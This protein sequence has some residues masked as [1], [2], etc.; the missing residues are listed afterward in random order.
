MVSVSSERAPPPD[1]HGLGQLFIQVTDP[2]YYA[3]LADIISP[4]TYVAHS[5]PG[6]RVCS[7]LCLGSFHLV[8]PIS[9]PVNL[10]DEIIWYPRTKAWIGL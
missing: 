3:Y 9:S 4:A 8:G 2:L 10:Q 6:L 7:L 1:L 5:N